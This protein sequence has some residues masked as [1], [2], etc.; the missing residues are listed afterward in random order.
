MRIAGSIPKFSSVVLQAR[1]NFGI[2]TLVLIMA[3]FIRDLAG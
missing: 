2:G 3:G 1:A